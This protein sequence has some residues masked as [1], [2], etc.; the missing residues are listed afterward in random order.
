MFLL[1][2]FTYK[3]ADIRGRRA[4][5]DKRKSAWPEIFTCFFPFLW[6]LNILNNSLN[7][8]RAVEVTG[9][10]SAVTLQVIGF[11]WG[12]R[13][14][15]GELNYV[16]LLLCPVKVGL[17]SVIRPGRSGVTGCGSLLDE[18][19]YCRSWL[20]AMGSYPDYM[21]ETITVP[22]Y[23]SGLWFTTQGAELAPQAIKTYLDGTMQ[24]VA[25]PLRL[26]RATN[27]VVVPT[28]A[29]VRI[30]ATAEDVTH[31]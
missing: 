5:G 10:Y 27:A 4:V 17:D 20:K 30:L 1:R 12:W 22:T 13:Y 24:V 8:I 19:Y 6:S 25:D 11:Q 31:S 2:I 3:R 26:L 23:Q 14:G 15:Y 28:R 29:V 16:K 7:I 9:S 21:K 18:V